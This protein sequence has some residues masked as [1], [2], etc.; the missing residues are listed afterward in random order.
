MNRPIDAEI[1]RAIRAAVR[2]EAPDHL[3]AILHQTER[4]DRSPAPAD[5][6]RF[7]RGAGRAALSAG[8]IAAAAVLLV[9]L[10]NSPSGGEPPPALPGFSDEPVVSGEFLEETGV[11]AKALGPAEPGEQLQEQLL[12]PNQAAV[13]DG[14]SFSW[15]S[16]SKLALGGGRALYR[17][18]LPFTLQF[19]AQN[20]AAVT[21]TVSDGQFEKKLY[22]D[23]MEEEAF[24]ERVGLVNRSGGRRWG[25]ETCGGAL[26]LPVGT[27]EAER[28]EWSIEL[29]LTE[30]A[31]LSSYEIETMFREKISRLEIYV[32][33]EFEDGSAAGTLLRFRLSGKAAGSLEAIWLA[34]EG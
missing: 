1:A 27:E 29:S 21:Y 22:A 12:A 13:I 26:R 2:A 14:G 28:E 34:R 10:R 5:C 9:F 3:E 20:L 16:P 31:S 32:T 25:Y 18:H 7:R 8:L 17:I 11:V 23:E 15:N 30:D 4:M 33:L 24:Q 6:A 19:Q